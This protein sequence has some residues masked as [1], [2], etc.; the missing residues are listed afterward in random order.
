MKRAGDLASLFCGTLLF[1]SAGS[2]QIISTVAGD[3]FCGDGGLAG[4]ACTR[5]PTRAVADL[6]GNLFIADTTNNRVRRVDAATGIITTV[7]GSGRYDFCGD[8]GLATSACLKSPQGLAVDADGNLFIADVN[9]SRIRRVDAV[10]QIITTVAGSRLFFFCGDGG[11][12][13]S[14]CLQ[15]PRAVAFDAAGN[16]L[17]ADTGDHRIRVVDAA[18]GIITTVAGNGSYATCGDGGPAIDACVGFP[19]GLAVG[20]DGSLFIV[21]GLSVR[22]VDAGTQIITTVAGSFDYGFCGDG[23]PATSAC[24]NNALDLAVDAQGNLFIADAGNNRIRRVDAATQII[25]TFAGDGSLSFCGDGGPAASAC[26]F[27]PFGVALDAGGNVLV[28]DTHNNRIRSIDAAG[29]ID[30]LAGN[31]S[32]SFCGD[33]DPAITACLGSPFGIAFDAGG[34]LLIA[35]RDNH[36]IRRIDAAT[37]IIS[38]VAGNGRP[39]FCGDGGPATSACLNSPNAIAIDTDGNLFIADTTNRRVRRVDA[40]TGIITTVV[41]N[42]Q[43]GFCGDG[44]PGVDACVTS[45]KGLAVDAEGNVFI[46]DSDNNR[47]R[48][49][50]AATSIITTAAG[51]IALSDCP[52]G[53]PATEFC[54]DQP[55]GLAFDGNGNLFITDYYHA[56]IRRVDGATGILTTVALIIQSDALAA[57]G[58]G[59]L[60]I[61]DTNGSRVLRLDAASGEITTVA[62]IHIDGFCGDG[63]PP[64]KACLNHPEGL[65]VDVN[66]NLFVSDTSN[67]RIRVVQ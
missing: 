14:A 61:A 6:K 57:D 41:G 20:P 2:A 29:I 42:G 24:F 30:T 54:L 31:G 55:R 7:A 62:G 59:N 49:L 32:E 9:N 36:R 39:G 4:R 23:G 10:T 27:Q 44:G 12:A 51:G 21:D 35:D 34:D 43:S 18:T 65:A 56:R 8:D 22:R 52:D 26:L 16:L 11:P 13:T 47:I 5:G 53:V 67:L 46:A 19:E 48:R 63:G 1:S 28:A 38:T 25:T 37:Q 15:T 3:T 58:D 17:V 40:Q 45:P 64:L 33:G 50:D 66:K 60:F